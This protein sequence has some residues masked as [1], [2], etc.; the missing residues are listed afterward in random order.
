MLEIEPPV[1][2][3]QEQQPALVIA[4]EPVKLELNAKYG[5]KGDPGS[6]GPIGPAGEGAEVI[7]PAGAAISGHKIVGYDASGALVHA[8]NTDLNSFSS[9]LGLALNAALI[10][11]DVTVAINREVTHSGWSWV[12]GVPIFLDASG[13]LTQTPPAFPALFSLQVAFPTSPTS[14]WIEVQTA[15][16]L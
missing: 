4:P 1:I 12:M 6:V 15:I 9:V 8:D 7:V 10:G 16:E 5:A 14:A 11:A 13:S 3:L 2:V